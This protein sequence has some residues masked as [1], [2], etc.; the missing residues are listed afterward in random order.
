MQINWEDAPEWANVVVYAYGRLFYLEHN[1]RGKITYVQRVDSSGGR[2]ISTDNH[3]WWSYDVVDVRPETPLK[4]SH[5]KR[6]HE[7]EL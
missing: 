7:P 3:V 2:M 6:K 5:R 1:H 4:H